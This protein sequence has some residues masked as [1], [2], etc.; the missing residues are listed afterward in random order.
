[1]GIERKKQ[2][3]LGGNGPEV[4]GEKGISYGRKGLQNPDRPERRR[5]VRSS[6]RNG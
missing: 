3:C 2:V 4:D 6:R 1:M 5:R